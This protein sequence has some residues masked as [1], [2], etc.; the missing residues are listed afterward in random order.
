MSSVF[1]KVLNF[2]S[3][4]IGEELVKGIMDRIP[5]KL[6]EHEE[7]NLKLAVMEATRQHELKMYELAVEDEKEFNE[8]IKELE[9]TGRDLRQAGWLGRVV[10]FFRGL[11]RPIWGYM[12]L[13]LDFMVYSGKWNLQEITGGNPEIQSQLM[14]AFW[15]INLLV[16]GFLFGERA[17]KNVLPFFKD[18]IGKIKSS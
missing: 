13:V 4:G 18:T 16:L 7:A 6:N 12:V 2:V 1:S 17:M 5:N 9:G 14:S 8:R 11:Q 10:L 3:G 15:V